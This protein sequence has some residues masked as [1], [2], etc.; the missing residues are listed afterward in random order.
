MF[1][2]MK[3]SPNPVH[4]DVREIIRRAIALAWLSGI[5]CKLGEQKSGSRTK[6]ACVQKVAAA[7]SQIGHHGIP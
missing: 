6:Q 7:G 3:D 5:G 1:A 4:F 2:V